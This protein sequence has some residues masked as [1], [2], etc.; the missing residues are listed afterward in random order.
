MDEKR[1]NEQPMS[2]LNDEQR[3]KAMAEDV[4]LADEL[5]DNVAGGLHSHGRAP[6]TSGVIL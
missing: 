6:K 4:E 3:E 5:M 1:I 2:S